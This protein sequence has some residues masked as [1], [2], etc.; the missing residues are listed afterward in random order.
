MEA[1]RT[2]T[3]ATS[4]RSE[5]SSR[6]QREQERLKTPTSREPLSMSGRSSGIFCTPPHLAGDPQAPAMTRSERVRRDASARFERE[7]LRLT[8]S[9]PKPAA[10]KPAKPE[11]IP[12]PRVVGAEVPDAPTSDEADTSKE[13]A[14]SSSSATTPQTVPPE[15]KEGD[16]ASIDVG[17]SVPPFPLTSLTPNQDWRRVVGDLT[18]VPTTDDE[19]L[20]ACR[21]ELLD[22][23]VWARVDDDGNEVAARVRSVVWRAEKIVLGVDVLPNDAGFDLPRDST[24]AAFVDPA[25]VSLLNMKELLDLPPP[26]PP[27]NNN[28]ENKPPTPVAPVKPS[29]C[30]DLTPPQLR[31]A[32]T[33]SWAEKSSCDAALQQQDGTPPPDDFDV[34]FAE[35]PGTCDLAKIFSRPSLTVHGY[36]ETGDWS[37]D[38]W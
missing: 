16:W 31:P 3:S 14:S 30:D 19:R 12:P 21:G 2:P 32:R 26:P 20:A 29:V 6:R 36:R 10:T 13:E 7:K 15:E 27:F 33:P 38:D 37:M 23:V 1:P 22:K 18:A 34:C 11:T 5:M 8:A 9:Q 35:A 25:D 4:A 17:V 28:D 24:G